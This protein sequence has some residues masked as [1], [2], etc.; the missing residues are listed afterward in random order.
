MQ[1]IVAVVGYPCEYIVPEAGR[2]WVKVLTC[3][4]GWLAFGATWGGRLDNE[5]RAR[6]G[7]R[8]GCVGGEQEQAWEDM[9]W[10]SWA[11]AV[12]D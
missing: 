2:A 6:G 12:V 8:G 10:L 11:D 1:R 4:A 9:G 5:R 3:Q 7:A